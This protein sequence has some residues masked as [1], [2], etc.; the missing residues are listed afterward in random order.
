[1]KNAPFAHNKIFSLTV[2]TII[3]TANFINALVQIVPTAQSAQVSQT[4]ETDS[5]LAVLCTHSGFNFEQVH[6]NTDADY[7]SYWYNPKHQTNYSSD[8]VNCGDGVTV[9]D[10]RYNGG[11]KLQVAAT[12]YTELTDPTKT[13]EVTNLAV[14]TEQ[15]DSSYNE[16]ISPTAYTFDSGIDTKILSGGPEA[17]NTEVAYPLP[18]DF[19]YYGVNYIKDTDFFYLCTNGSINFTPGNC[20]EPTSPLKNVLTDTSPR[21][22]PYYKK[23]YMNFPAHGIYAHLENAS[24]IRFTWHAHNQ[25][26]ELISSSPVEF[27]IKIKD[28]VSLPNN[29]YGD[30]ISFHY[31]TTILDANTMP[32][33]GLSKGGTVEPGNLESSIYTE[34]I[35][36][37]ENNPTGLSGQGTTFSPSGFDYLETKKANTPATIALTNGN[38]HSD[39]DYHTFT[40]PIVDLLDGASP[41]TGGRIGIY[42]IYPSYRLNIPSTTP[43]GIYRSEITYTLSDSSELILP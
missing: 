30:T 8:P 11:F 3:F 24:T 4:I 41:P 42:T 36:K 21:I 6:I 35:L 32:I 15:L 22:M 38:P 33:I 7:K 17:N 43:A 31:P 5:T 27:Q 2:I 18:F 29:N 13:I 20:T 25:H 40:V 37:I 14:V 1:M 12:T 23:L 10:K 28:N 16:V 26:P 9:Y 19:T 39:A 34:S